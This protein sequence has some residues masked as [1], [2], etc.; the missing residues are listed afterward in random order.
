MTDPLL[1]AGLGLLI[2]L[3]GVGWLIASVRIIRYFRDR[4]GCFLPAGL[5]LLA[6]LLLIVSG[7]GFVWCAIT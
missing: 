3:L 1:Q 2:A 4:I 5:I 6:G 7:L